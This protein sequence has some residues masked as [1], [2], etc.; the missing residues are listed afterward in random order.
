MRTRVVKEERAYGKRHGLLARWFP[1]PR[2]LSRV[3]AGVDISDSS[4]KWVEL[5]GAESGWEV[6]AYGSTPLA[7]GV[8]VEGVVRDTAQLAAAL[9]SLRTSIGGVKSV[10]ASLPEEAGYVFS[11]TV[12]DE[13]EREQALH[14][15]EFELEGRVP[16]KVDQ[17]VYDYDMVGPT[18]RGVEIGVTVFPRTLITGYE[19]AFA[20]AGIELRSLEVEAR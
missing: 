7:P 13:K 15:I 1:T 9:S 2:L 11:M 17:A 18:E 10:H 4:I 14:M 8:V 19:E 20:E 5:R 3:G 12:P 16:L 6:G